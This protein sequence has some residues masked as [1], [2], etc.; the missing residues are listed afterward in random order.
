[1]KLNVQNKVLFIMLICS[2]SSDLPRM[3]RSSLLGYFW[4]WS[5]NNLKTFSFRVLPDCFP[6]KKCIPDK[7]NYFK[8][9]FRLSQQ[10]QSIASQQEAI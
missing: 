5:K 2:Y 6:V 9:F 1:M 3:K 8:L 4:W 10:K 7:Y